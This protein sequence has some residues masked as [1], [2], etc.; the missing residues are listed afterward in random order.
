MSK[1][2]TAPAAETE[3]A[4]PASIADLVAERHQAL[5]DHEAHKEVGED[6]DDEPAP[7]AAVAAKTAPAP[8]AEAA[9]AAKVETPVD[10]AAKPE[11]EQPFWYRKEIEK[12]R[13]A[14]QAGRARAADL[15]A[16]RQPAPQQ[17]RQPARK[18]TRTARSPARNWKPTA[19]MT[20]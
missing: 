17:Q 16:Q 1:A 14:R 8:V 7:A 13:K 9:P 2:D 12:E 15:A 5:P 6:P 19:S 3:N 4:E 18:T 20:P 10:P 11:T